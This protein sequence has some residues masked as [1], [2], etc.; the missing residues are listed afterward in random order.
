MQGGVI[1]PKLNTQ[2]ILLWAL[3]CPIGPLKCKKYIVRI[4]ALWFLK[5]GVPPYMEFT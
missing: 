1:R 3:I 5:G 2:D 4:N